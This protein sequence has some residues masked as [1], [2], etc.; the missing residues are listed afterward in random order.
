MFCQHF[1]WMQKLIAVI[2]GE[3]ISQ[4]KISAN[5]P[6][7]QTTKQ[8]LDKIFL[9]FFISMDNLRSCKQLNL[10]VSTVFIWCLL[11]FFFV[12]YDISWSCHTVPRKIHE[13]ESFV[14][15][16]TKRKSL[17]WDTLY[18]MIYWHPL[19]RFWCQAWNL[20]YVFE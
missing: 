14:I 12:M 6:Q 7:R 11:G 2:L 8:S 20:T 19:Q 5:L 15:W 3:I 9:F 10:F 4:G 18:M 16:T 13:I 17:L 1:Q